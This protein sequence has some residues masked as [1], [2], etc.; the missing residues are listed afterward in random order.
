MRGCSAGSGNPAWKGGKQTFKC[1]VCGNSFERFPSVGGVTCSLSCAAEKSRQDC[2]K[3]KN[4]NWRGGKEKPCLCCG[5]AF[6][7]YP[8]RNSIYCSKECS[9]TMQFQDKTAARWQ[10]GSGW[11]MKGTRSGKRVDLG[12]YVRSAWEANYARYLNWMV[13][14]GHFKGWEYEAETFEFVGIKKG[15]RFYTP[16]FKVQLL[17]GDYEYH[18]VKGWMHPKGKTALTRMKKYHPS[19]KIVLIQKEEYGNLA[20]MMK[21]VISEWE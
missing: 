5:K 20:R 4:C 21:G 11:G 2:S 8:S 14:K 12:I 19:I 10:S 15:T 13:S 17:N 3:E 16:D 6:W 1:A 7:V 18:E 9:H